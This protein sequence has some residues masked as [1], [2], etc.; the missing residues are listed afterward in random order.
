MECFVCGEP[1]E[2]L[3]RI[4]DY[5]GRKCPLCGPYR[6]SGSLM[7]QLKSKRFDIEKTRDRLQKARSEYSEPTLTTYDEDLL[8]DPGGQA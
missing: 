4:G 8:V 3:E 1:A 2:E 5:E 6:V 7:P